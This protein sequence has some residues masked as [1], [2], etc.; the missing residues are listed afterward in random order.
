MVKQTDRAPVTGD[1]IA[2]SLPELM[3]KLNCGRFTAEKIATAAGAKIKVG[4]RTLYHVGKI[5]E[6]L[7]RLSNEQSVN[8]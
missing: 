8:G 6:Y 3:A 2:I 1:V 5:E 4:R 7:T